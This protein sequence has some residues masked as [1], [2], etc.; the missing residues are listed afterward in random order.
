MPVKLQ[1]IVFQVSIHVLLGYPFFAGL[2]PHID[3]K[4]R[5]NRIWR[6]V[7]VFEVTADS[8]RMVTPTTDVLEAE[9]MMISPALMKECGADTAVRDRRAEVGLMRSKDTKEVDPLRRQW[10]G[11][12]R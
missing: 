2:Q 4:R 8:Y 7:K 10:R 12:K 1:L 6:K 3:W 9:I 5:L 11:V